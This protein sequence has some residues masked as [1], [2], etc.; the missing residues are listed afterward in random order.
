MFCVDLVSLDEL[1][2]STLKVTAVQRA[3]GT[4]V[5]GV[6]VQF[7][8]GMS[9]KVTLNAAFS[10]LREALRTSCSKSSM[11]FLICV[12]LMWKSFVDDASRAA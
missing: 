11:H 1:S 9:A 4:I 12:V 2:K 3:G 10:K 5:D 8:R 7:F 6:I